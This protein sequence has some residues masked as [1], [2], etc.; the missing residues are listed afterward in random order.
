MMYLKVE[1]FHSFA[2][3]PIVIYAE[4]DDDRWET[5]KIEVFRNGELGFSDG[6]SE[7]H[8]MGLSETQIPSIEEIGS[9]PE[10]SPRI[11]TKDE[12]ER[13]WAQATSRA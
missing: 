11:I 10:F 5:R 7:C 6:E 2:D 8:S 13:M 12:F 1:W 4:I 3:E 9:D